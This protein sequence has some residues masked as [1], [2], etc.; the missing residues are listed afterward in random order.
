MSKIHSIVLE[1]QNGEKVNF[2]FEEFI[3]RDIKKSVTLVGKDGTYIFEVVQIKDDLFELQHVETRFNKQA[4]EN[5]RVVGISF[6]IGE[7]PEEAI[8][9]KF[10]IANDYEKPI[11]FLPYLTSANL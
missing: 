1:S 5:Y 3:A 10:I 7:T 2:N 11:D 4:K 6:Q 9:Y 8:D